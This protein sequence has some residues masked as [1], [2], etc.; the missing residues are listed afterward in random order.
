MFLFEQIFASSGQ[1]C[2]KLRDEDVDTIFEVILDCKDASTQA[3][4][5]VTLQA[6]AKV[7]EQYIVVFNL[8]QNFLIFF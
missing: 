4:L 7:F 5:M 2:L 1:F 8:K 6:M 3:Q